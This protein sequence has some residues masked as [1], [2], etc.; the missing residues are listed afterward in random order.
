VRK[1]LK[2]ISVSLMILVMTACSATRKRSTERVTGMTDARAY[3]AVI[4]Q[5]RNNNIAGEGFYVR[6]GKIDLE[7]T[8]I[9]GSYGFNA[10]YNSRGDL[11]AS[12]K[13]PLGIELLRL[14]SVNGKIYLVDRI[15]K[16]VYRGST[17]AILTKYGLPD[18]VIAVIFGDLISMGNETYSISGRERIMI[19][20][21]MNNM[22]READICIDEEK[23]C[24]EIY[25]DRISGNE[26]LLRYSNFKNTEGKKYA[27]LIYMEEKKKKV[28]IRIRIDELICGYE[29]E[30]NFAMPSYRVRDL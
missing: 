22:Q 18:N 9:D 14:L 25:K 30:I 28:Q 11:N 15:G 17:S 12:V 3:N 19:R 8:A 16:T 10:R 7:G 20:G 21:D 13:G 4:E 24:E 29:E 5:V 2:I 27:S 26:V 6:K 1:D 23:I